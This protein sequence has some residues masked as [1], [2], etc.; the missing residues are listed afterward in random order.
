MILRA[1]TG[2]WQIVMADLSLLLFIVT[3]AG[4]MNAPEAPA[5]ALQHAQAA[6]PVPQSDVALTVWRGPIGAPG[7][8]IW[9]EEQMADAPGRLAITITYPPGGVAAAIAE[10]SRLQT[11]A[12]P[13]GTD[14]RIVIREGNIAS[15]QAVLV[16]DRQQP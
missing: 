11:E 7:L 2:R 14:A 6:R 15:A 10:A 12:G 8:G 16:Q 5:P 13:R 9:L 1:P 3:M 4:L